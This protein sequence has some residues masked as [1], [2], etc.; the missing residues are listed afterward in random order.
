MCG[1]AWVCGWVYSCFGFVQRCPWVCTCVDVCVHVGGYVCACVGACMGV[2]RDNT[3]FSVVVHV[4]PYRYL[5][6]LRCMCV[7]VCVAANVSV[8]NGMPGFL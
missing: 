5:C 4:C 3:V 7:C 6:V 8:C 1:C 2:C